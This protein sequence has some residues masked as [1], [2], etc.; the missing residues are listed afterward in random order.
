M[1][2]IKPVKS[3]QDAVYIKD[4]KF[5]CGCRVPIYQVNTIHSL[6]QI[7]GY[8][9]YI[10][11]SYGNV[12]YR[13]QCRLYDTIKPGIYRNV[14]SDN[15]MQRRDHWLKK[16]IENAK[17]DKE[18]SKFIHLENSFKD[19]VMLES[20]F[21]HYGIPTHYIDVVDN[22]WIALWFGAYK[23]IPYIYNSFCK[24]E[25]RSININDA[26]LHK[27]GLSDA[28]F[29]AYLAT[30]RED[31]YQYILLIAAS[32]PERPIN[33]GVTIGED[34]ISVDLRHALP[35]TFL[36]PHAQH[37]WTVRKKTLSNDYDDLDL[38]DHVVGILRIRVC[39]ALKWI[40]NGELLTQESLFPN[41]NFD[42]GYN[43][44]LNHADYFAEANWK[45][46]IY[47]S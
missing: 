14:N 45:I 28:E 31:M 4:F 18:F 47:V 36:R 1:E 27:I 25:M 15:A 35:S 11:A 17:G 33:E 8:V 21:Q 30:I 42:Q 29:D 20:V 22:H 19:Q 26:L 9:K 44:L 5:A 38:A 39:D 34:T 46:P 43:V 7:I 37:G 40:G 23:Y 3:I 32:R 10:N 2:V 41:P 12:L 13:G 16:A 24:Y 6:T